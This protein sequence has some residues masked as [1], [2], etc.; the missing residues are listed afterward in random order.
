MDKL[1]LN[2]DGTIVTLQIEDYKEYDWCNCT[3]G[4]F[5][6]GMMKKLVSRYLPIII[7]Y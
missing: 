1:E 4:D 2:L 6:F 7:W 5:A 3:I